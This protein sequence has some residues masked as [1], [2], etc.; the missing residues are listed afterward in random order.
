M[1][2]LPTSLLLCVTALTIP[3]IQFASAEELDEELGAL[4]SEIEALK[5]GQ[6]AIRQ[7]LRE[8]KD[9]LTNRQQPSSA[10][11][12][13]DFTLNVAQAPVKGAVNARVTLIEFSD[14]QCPFCARHTHTVLP[15]LE[16]EYIDTGKV[17]YVLR[18]Y[19]MQSIH[20]QAPK[21][22]EAALCA[23]DQDKYWEMHDQLFANQMNLQAEQLPMYAQRIRLADLAAFERCLDSGKYTESIKA[24]VTEGTKAGVRGTPSFLL[25]LTDTN[26]SVKVVKSIQGAQSYAVFQKVIDELLMVTGF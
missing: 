24:S 1:N 2:R 3:H 17:R 26:G 12:D 14:Y 18:D 16:K 13:V 19:P 22:H 21:A 8:I 15:Q 9:L 7:E 5:T 20:P 23:G 4:R 6:E 10:V 25:G 11:S